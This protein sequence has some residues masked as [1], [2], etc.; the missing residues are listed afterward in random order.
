MSPEKAPLLLPQ[1]WTGADYSL[2]RSDYGS[3]PTAHGPRTVGFG[4]ALGI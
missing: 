1:P 2:R 3:C 4:N